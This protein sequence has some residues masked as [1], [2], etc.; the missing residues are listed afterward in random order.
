MGFGARD[1]LQRPG[2]AR[3]KS[4]GVLSFQLRKSLRNREI[5]P[6][7]VVREYMNTSKHL[8]DF[9]AKPLPNDQFY[10]EV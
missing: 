1:S 9:I 3:T 8:A 2:K 4:S 7:E 10:M 5:P 6:Y